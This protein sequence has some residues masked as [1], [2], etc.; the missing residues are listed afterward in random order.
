MLIELGS[1]IF[2]LL[3]IKFAIKE[4]N[5]FSL[6]EKKEIKSALERELSKPTK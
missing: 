4:Y 1:L 2:I 6:E 5:K 3:L